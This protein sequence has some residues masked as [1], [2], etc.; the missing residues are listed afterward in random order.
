M[1]IS[2]V[3]PSTINAIPLSGSFVPETFKNP[4]WD[5]QE[6]FSFFLTCMEQGDLVYSCPMKEFLEGHNKV[7]RFNNEV[8]YGILRYKQT[9]VAVVY[10]PKESC[11]ASSAYAEAIAYDIYEKAIFP[12]TGHHFV[13]PTIVRN[14]QDERIASVQFFVETGRDE[15]MWNDGFREQVLNNLPHD[16]IQELAVFNAVF[17]DWDRHPG[18]F[19]ANLRDGTF[20]LATIDNESIENRGILDQWG[21]RAFIPTLFTKDERVEQQQ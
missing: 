14:M 9:D 12:Y 17:N 3:A 5:P 6:D 10:K 18:N 1:S 21:E 2:L 16:T 15:D 7:A 19:L 8:H 20:Y 11:D 4:V 13:P